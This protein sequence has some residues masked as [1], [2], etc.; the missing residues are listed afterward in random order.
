MLVGE[1][2]TSGRCTSAA[3]AGYGGTGRG[4]TIAFRTAAAG[5]PEY[6]S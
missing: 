1:A 2:Y 5:E 4:C 6:C 3:V